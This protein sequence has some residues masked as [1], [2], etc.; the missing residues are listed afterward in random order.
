[1]T[2]VKDNHSSNSQDPR[3]S[4]SLLLSPAP[5]AHIALIYEN[6]KQRDLI[7]A[8]Y[9][10]E[11]LR[12]GQICV[13][14]TVFYRDEGHLERF[15]KLI[16]NCK[17]NLNNGNLLIVDLASFYISALLGDMQPFEEAKKMFVEKAKGRKNKHVRFYGDCTGFLFKNNHFDECTIVEEWW[18]Q[19]KLFDGTCLC[20]F[21][22]Q[23]FSNALPHE[24]YAKRTIVDTHDI[25]VDDDNNCSM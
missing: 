21:P 6:K 10:N 5:K 2:A 13:Y 16:T 25:V 15:S 18:Q 9:I 1:M 20:S 8:N 4:S 3:A 22:K 17:E 12:L 11:G 7:I 19:Q 23:F 24:L 14:A